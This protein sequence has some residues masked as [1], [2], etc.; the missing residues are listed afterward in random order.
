MLGFTATVRRR[1]EIDA[2][3]IVAAVTELTT[4]TTDDCVDER[5]CDEDACTT[6]TYVPGAVARFGSTK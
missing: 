3:R 6:Y 4:T 2:E 1:D 5:D